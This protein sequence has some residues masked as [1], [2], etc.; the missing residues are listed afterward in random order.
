MRQKKLQELDLRRITAQKRFIKLANL[1][2]AAFIWHCDNKPSLMLLLTGAY[3][4]QFSKQAILEAEIA[5]IGVENWKDDLEASC[6]M[7]CYAPFS[8][9]NR[10]HHCRLCGSIVDSQPLS[11]TGKS[12]CS[13]Q[14]PV[15]ILL[16]M[17]PHLNYLPEL[18]K[19]WKVLCDADTTDAKLS[20]IFSFRCCK[21]CKNLLTYNSKPLK[22]EEEDI[23]LIFTSYDQF[24]MLKQLISDLERRFCAQL[25]T[26]SGSDSQ[27]LKLR[28]SMVDSIKELESKV[29]FFKSRVSLLDSASSE[30]KGT[31]NHSQQV[32]EMNMYKAMM[33]FLS[34]AVQRLKKMNDATENAISFSAA[35]K[36]SSTFSLPEVV[37]PRLS[38]REIRERREQL[39]VTKE[40]KFLVEELISNTRK[41][42][43][44]DEVTTLEESK[45][46]LEQRIE[47]LEEELGEFRF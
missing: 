40:Q 18:K 35:S 20:Q 47:E 25:T 22:N 3:S 31:E 30:A 36:D 21:T 37:L 14:V 24:L 9:V 5:I 2:G 26:N 33:L 27:L 17:L 38:K 19:S 28:A 4:T 34:E 41:L 46:D 1:L 11:Y 45:R 16:K 32:L 13:A 44:F 12:P 43:K 7:L 15:S 8:L 10:K 23:K 39:M 42:R 29:S 6:C